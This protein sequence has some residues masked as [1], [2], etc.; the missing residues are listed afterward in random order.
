[1]WLQA[2]IIAGYLCNTK[3]LAVVKKSI[4]QEAQYSAENYVPLP[5]VSSAELDR[6]VA[7]IREVLADMDSIRMAS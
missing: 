4:E 3:Q 7:Q 1:M 6:A 5:V 2:A